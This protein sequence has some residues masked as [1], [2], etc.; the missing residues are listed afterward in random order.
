MSSG[1]RDPNEISFLPTRTSACSS[2]R[3]FTFQ[4]HCCFTLR[5]QRLG[6]AKVTLDS[7]LVFNKK[8]AQCKEQA[9]KGVEWKG[10]QGKGE[11][12]QGHW[13]FSCFPLQLPHSTIPMHF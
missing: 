13:S 9:R 6:S 10:G 4:P 5:L 11:G 8:E 1:G 2:S 7:V 3:A 12:K